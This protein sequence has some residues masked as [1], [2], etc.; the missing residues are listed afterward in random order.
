MA[1]YPY[2]F[3][4][5][6]SR[7]CSDHIPYVITINTDI[8]KARAFRF[9]NYWMLHDEFMEIVENCWHILNYQTDKAKKMG[10]KLKHLRKILRQWHQW[11]SNLAKTIENN[12]SVI[13]LLDIMEEFRDV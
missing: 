12:K 3:A 5:S 7:D 11:L 10:A 4:S 1:K 8:P 13:P 9:E 2:S 6:L